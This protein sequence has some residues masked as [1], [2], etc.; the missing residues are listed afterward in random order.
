MMYGVDSIIE[1]QVSLYAICRD[2]E[3]QPSATIA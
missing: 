2:P 3:F 1:H